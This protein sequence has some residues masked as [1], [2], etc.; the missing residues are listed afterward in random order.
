MKPYSTLGQVTL[1]SQLRM[2]ADAITTD[3]SA[4][5]SHFDLA[6]DAKWFPVFYVLASEKDSTVTS[7]ATTIGHSHVSVSKTIAE[8]ETAKLTV[9]KKSPTDSRRTLINLSPE[10][11]KLVPKLETQC[12][13]VD[14][15]LNQLSD[16]TGI[17]LGQ[18]LA[19][20]RQHLR[21]YPLSERVKSLGKQSDLKIIDY[22]PHH[23][24][25]FKRLNVEWIT[26]YW[27]LEAADEESLNCPTKYIIDKGGAIFIALFKN[28][29]VGS[30]ALIRHD[31]T[32]LELA[33][34][35]VSP[36]VQG[37]GIGL[38]LG[39]FAL[40]RAQ[41]MGARRVFLESNSKLSPALS[42]YRKLGFVDI[43]DEGEASPYERCNVRMEIAIGR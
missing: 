9:S 10:G 27:K 7:I 22:A 34:M 3:A 39:Q 25:D 21:Y 23:A 29:P 11:K 5:Y 26:R 18:A 42:L 41:K 32:T 33:K 43:I 6:I 37:K 20:T 2:L 28:E 12:Q 4:I 14:D 40:E 16:E 8:L 36:A 19:V 38:A 17:N 13:H 15:A 31:D 35:A 30:V 1:G 24:D